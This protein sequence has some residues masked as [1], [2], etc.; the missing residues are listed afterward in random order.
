[1]T[2]LRV[3]SWQVNGARSTGPRSLTSTISASSH[4]AVKS[5][6]RMKAMRVIGEAFV[7]GQRGA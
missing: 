7:R 6:A 2:L 1:M 3:T 5:R 4:G